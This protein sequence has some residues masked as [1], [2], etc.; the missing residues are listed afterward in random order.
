MDIQEHLGFIKDEE[1][2]KPIKEKT[3]TITAKEFEI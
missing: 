1:G 3:V 2:V